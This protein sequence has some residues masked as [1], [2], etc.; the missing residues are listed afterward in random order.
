MLH[1]SEV[2]HPTFTAVDKSIFW[3]V[4]FAMSEM[5]GPFPAI[6]SATILASS[7]RVFDVPTKSSLPEPFTMV[8]PAKTPLR[9]KPV[10]TPEAS[11]HAPK[12]KQTCHTPF[13]VHWCQLIY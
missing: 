10:R 13:I 5:V 1:H 4:F 7:F 9:R 11:Q 8:F 6:I 12:A 3:L 2:F